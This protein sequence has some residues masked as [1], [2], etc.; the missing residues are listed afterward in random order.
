MI[1]TILLSTLILFVIA[2]RFYGKSL[3]KWVNTNR[4]A[5]TPAHTEQDG[6]DY[7]PTS[8]IVLFGH[9]F[10]SIAGAGPIIGPIVAAKIFG[11]GPALL[12]IIIGAIF[13]GGVHDYLSHFISVRHKGYSIGE[14]CRIYLSPLTYKSFL[15]FTFVALIYVLIVFLD[16]TANTFAASGAVATASSSYIVIAV[17]F[18]LI[19]KLL[20]VKFLVATAIFLPLVFLSL[21]F[22]IQFPLVIGGDAKSFWIII[23][24]I[25]CF[26]AS[27][28]PVWILLQPRDY[29]SS[30]LL[31]ACLIIGTIGVFVGDLS[32]TISAQF[33]AFISLWKNPDTHSGFIF[34]TLFIVI[35]C[36]AVSGFHSLVGSGTTSKQLD[37]ED[38]ALK[39]TYGA[40]L[41]EGILAVIALLAVIIASKGSTVL[42]GTPNE[43]FANAMG[44]FA[45]TF[46]LS[47]ETGYKFGLLAISTFLL[48]TLDTA[49]RLSRLI[50]QEFFSLKKPVWR[51]I[52]TLVTV[53]IPAI[54]VFMKFPDGKGGFIPAWKIIWPVFGATNQLLAAMA[55]IVVYVWIK[56][57]GKKANFVLYPM[58]FM[59]ITSIWAL[60]GNVI[61]STNGLIT[62]TAVVLIALGSFVI[63]DS[64]RVI[65]KGIEVR[66]KE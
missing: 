60:V 57:A 10:S 30:Y 23:L 24:L 12:W 13:V 40:M 19:T 34:P 64:I 9:H 41:V 62:A 65:R 53:L 35:A 11:W 25:Y 48:T 63:Y 14:I 21:H 42:S 36:G 7:V 46:G 1:S 51:Y 58:I 6:V 49:T 22:G 20:R 8:W 45:Q 27:T 31:A 15:I 17:L 33:P 3:A 47:P 55:L 26:I 16:L 66:G 4:Q 32:G 50:F 5:K 43:I 18:G 56:S 29:L 37:N 28:A 39:V 54:V 52:S 59:I 38:H 2:Y 61:N 44:Q